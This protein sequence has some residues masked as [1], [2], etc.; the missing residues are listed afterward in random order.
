MSK[1]RDVRR[2]LLTVMD[3]HE[4]E[5]V[6]AGKD[7]TMIRKAIVAG[8]FF[9]V[10][11]RDPH[12]GYRT[13]VDNKLVYVHPSSVLFR[14]QPDWVIYNELVM[15]TKEYMREISVIESKWLMELVPGFLR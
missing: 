5:V 6:G 14:R 12:D 2:Q 8:F 15:T 9:Q 4:L 10:V 13:I 1:A 7:R 3:T 11:K